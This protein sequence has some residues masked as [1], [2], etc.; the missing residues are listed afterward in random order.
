MFYEIALGENSK[1][2]LPIPTLLSRGAYLTV[3]I[4]RKSM[5]KKAAYQNEIGPARD[6]KVTRVIYVGGR[7]YPCKHNKA[8]KIFSIFAT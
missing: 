5:R 4:A 1:I 8:V 6:E 7:K 2:K 3:F